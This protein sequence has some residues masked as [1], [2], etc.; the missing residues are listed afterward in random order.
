MCVYITLN[1]HWDA[2]ESRSGTLPILAPPPP[3][4]YSPPHSFQLILHF[5]EFLATSFKER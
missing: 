1:F 5:T 3:H 2:S 4:W